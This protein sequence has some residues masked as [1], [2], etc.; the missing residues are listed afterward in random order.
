[1]KALYI[2]FAVAGMYLPTFAVAQISLE[3]LRACLAIEDQTKERLDCY[4][5]KIKPST[6]TG[7]RSGHGPVG[8]SVLTVSH[9]PMPIR[10]NTATAAVNKVILRMCH[11]YIQPTIPPEESREVGHR[12]AD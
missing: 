10:T 11:L 8:A 1:M 6:E 4:D 3:T 9:V 5:D 7:F 2:L 12:S